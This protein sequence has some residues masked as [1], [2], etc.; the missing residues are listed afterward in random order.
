MEVVTGTTFIHM[1]YVRSWSAG[2]QI[3]EADEENELK[4]MVE[5]KFEAA[6]CTVY[7]ED[8][9]EGLIAEVVAS[10]C[11]AVEVSLNK[12]VFDCKQACSDTLV[13]AT[14]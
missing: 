3:G 11:K 7:T 8:V 6:E 4:E 14:S 12:S 2:K 13:P 10:L 1:L 5:G 9:K